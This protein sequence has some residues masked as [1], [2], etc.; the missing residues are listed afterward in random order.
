MLRVKREL[1]RVHTKLAT[2]FRSQYRGKFQQPGLIE[3]RFVSRLVKTAT[4]AMF[5]HSFILLAKHVARFFTRFTV[6]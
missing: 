2:I 5:R 1:Y 6:P 3:D 4:L